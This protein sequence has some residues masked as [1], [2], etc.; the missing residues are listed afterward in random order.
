MALT[1]ARSNRTVI[2]APPGCGAVNSGEPARLAKQGKKK[3]AL[4][5]PIRTSKVN[6]GALTTADATILVSGNGAGIEGSVLKKISRR[7]SERSGA[8]R[9]ARDPDAGWRPGAPPCVQS[10][11]GDAEAG[12]SALPA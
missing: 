2:Q 10:R 12:R 3:S 11:R 6:R 5:S 8:P 4:F 7:R 9:T 1:R